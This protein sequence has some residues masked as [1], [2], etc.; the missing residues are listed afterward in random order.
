[1]RCESFWLIV[2]GL[3]VG[4]AVAYSVRRVLDTGRVA[5]GSAHR[6]VRVDPMSLCAPIRRRDL[7]VKL[8]R[9]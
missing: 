2:L 9:G 8:R 5:F 7:H 3:A 1:V 4:L 6:A